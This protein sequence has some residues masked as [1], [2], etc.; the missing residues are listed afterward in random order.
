MI[1]MNL[2]L[3]FD[4]IRHERKISQE[5]FI[6]GIISMSQFRN[7]LNNESVIPLPII[8]EFSNRLGMKFDFILEDFDKQLKLERY[9]VTSMLNAV[10]N[11]DYLKFNEFKKQLD[12]TNFFEKH[13]DLLY[14]HSIILYNYNQKRASKEHSIFLMKKLI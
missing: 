8:Y 1:E 3:Y 13:N 4:K 11:Y 10:S 14:H 9:L 2:A 5:D 12:S 7:Y 6:D